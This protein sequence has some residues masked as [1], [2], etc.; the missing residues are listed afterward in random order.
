LALMYF[1]K[2]PLTHNRISYCLQ[3]YLLNQIAKEA[4]MQVVQEDKVLDISK[5][6]S[7]TTIVA[8]SELLTKHNIPCVLWDNFLLYLHGM[9]AIIDVRLYN[10]VS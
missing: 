1:D 3:I 9:P 10:T 2:L 4:E 6:I 8:I 7:E 5:G